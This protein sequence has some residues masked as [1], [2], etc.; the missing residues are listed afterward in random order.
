MMTATWQMVAQC[1]VSGI[2]VN[3]YVKKE[4]SH[5]ENILVQTHTK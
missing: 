4:I 3:P 1:H 5:R 2:F